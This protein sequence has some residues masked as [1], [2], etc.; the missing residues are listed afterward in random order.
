MCECGV[1]LYH[2]P[3]PLILLLYHVSL[4]CQFLFS[5]DFTWDQSHV[6]VKTLNMNFHCLHQALILLVIFTAGSIAMDMDQ[7]GSYE[8]HAIVFTNGSQPLIRSNITNSDVLNK[9][10]NVLDGYASELV[11]DMTFSGESD[12]LSL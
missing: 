12:S 10:T 9:L 3:V 1:V 11:Q 4:I 8:F 6:K 5:L 7:I 2:C